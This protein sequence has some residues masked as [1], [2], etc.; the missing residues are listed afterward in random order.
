LPEF[1]SLHTF[2]LRKQ[3]GQVIEDGSTLRKDIPHTLMGFIDKPGNL[4]IDLGGFGLTVVFTSVKLWC[5]QS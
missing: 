3:T 2:V 4:I 5:Y 1:I